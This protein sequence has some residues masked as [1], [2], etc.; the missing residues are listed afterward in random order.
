MGVVDVLKKNKRSNEQLK[1]KRH[2]LLT[3]SFWLASCPPE[4]VKEEE[5]FPG[6]DV[7]F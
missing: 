7:P 4:D 1:E 6:R 3:C 5:D 2:S